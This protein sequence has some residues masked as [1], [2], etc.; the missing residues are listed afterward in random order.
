MIMPGG[1]PRD[2]DS[3]QPVAPLNTCPVAWTA[4]ALTIEEIKGLVEAFAHAARRARE[5]GFD[6]VEIHGTHGY[7]LNQFLSPYSN[8]RTD[9]YGGSRENRMRFPLEVIDAVYRAVGEDFPIIFRMNAGEY[10]EGGL[11]LD[12][13]REIARRLSSSPVNALHVSAG[14]LRLPG[15]HGGHDGFAA[16]APGGACGRH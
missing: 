1:R 2:G 12:D 3:A 4:R 9:E 13:A 14:V 11:T 7:L 16:A 5:A 6:A 10:V 15:T 8:K